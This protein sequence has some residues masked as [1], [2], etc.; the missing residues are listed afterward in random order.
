MSI[1]I[2]YIILYYS[3]HIQIYTFECIVTLGMWEKNQSWVS[4]TNTDDQ[5]GTW[6][7]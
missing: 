2:Y 4:P 6:H 7:H 1:Y 3:A 5:V